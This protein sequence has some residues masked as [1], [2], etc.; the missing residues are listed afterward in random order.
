LG[1]FN[2]ILGAL[3]GLLRYALVLSLVFWFLKSADGKYKLIPESQAE[4][5]KLISP[6]GKVAPAVLPA[7]NKI[8]KEVK[9]KIL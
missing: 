1:I 7:L 9:A 4:K 3:F 5:S 6:L 8:N 2:K